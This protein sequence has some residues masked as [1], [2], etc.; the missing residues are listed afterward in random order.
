MDALIAARE[1]IVAAAEHNPLDEA[2]ISICGSH[3]DY[4]WDVKDHGP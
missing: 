3:Q 2:F 4:I 1:A